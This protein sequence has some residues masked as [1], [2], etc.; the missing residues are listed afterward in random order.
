M[1]K[2]VNE[3]VE[4]LSHRIPAAEL[5]T[6]R[7]V[8]LFIA[9]DY[10]ITPRNTELAVVTDELPQEA[11]EYLVTKKIEG[12]SEA[13]LRQY[14]Y[15]LKRFFDKVRK[16][17]SLIR[18]EDL[19][20]YLFQVKEETQMS[21]RSLENQR[22]YICSFFRWLMANGYLIKNPCIN[23]K[24]IKY[25]KKMREP[26]TDTEMES[27]RLACQTYK[28]KAVVEM[29]YSTGCRVSE[30][31]R[32]KVKDIDL[33]KREVHLFGKGKKHRIA[34]LNARAILNIRL[35]LGN[36]GYESEYVFSSDRKPHGK[37]CNRSIENIIGNLG[38][39]AQISGRVFPHR[40]RHTTATD[41]LRKGMP[42]DQVQQLLGHEKIETTLEYTKISRDEVKERHAKYIV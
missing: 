5:F 2:F 9:N 27:L 25:E 8:L 21:D 37:L 23:L 38:E 11:K 42:I 24:P 17:V 33:E 26:L 7:E 35:L 15:A 4:R 41:A 10:D 22:V 3:V 39:Q 6:V 1:E 32:I 31:A 13:T 36:R 29:L 16:P 20:I 18:T 40:I 12:M 34:Y 19:R 30:L 14:H 28:E